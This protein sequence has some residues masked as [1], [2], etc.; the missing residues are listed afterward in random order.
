MPNYGAWG[1][2]AQGGDSLMDAYMASKAMRQKQEA[3]RNKL[4]MEQSAA[5]SKADLEAAQARKDTA[6]AAQTEYENAPSTVSL[7]RAGLPDPSAGLPLS[8]KG[9]NGESILGPAQGAFL[10][11]KE[12]GAWSAQ[13]TKAKPNGSAPNPNWDG[14]LGSLHPNDQR[15]VEALYTGQMNPANISMRQGERERVLNLVHGVHPDYDEKNFP[16]M[17]TTIKS[18]ASGPDAGNKTSLNTVIGHLG[19]LQESAAQLANGSYPAVNAVENFVGRQMGHGK[20][21]DF[22]T[23]ADAVASE[24]GKVFKGTGALSDNEI[25]E[26]RHNLSQN[27]SP[28]QFKSAIDSM[29]GLIASR[30]QALKEKYKTGTGR[31]ADFKILTPESE[32]MLKKL[33]HDPAEVEGGMV[34]AGGND[35]DFKAAEKVLRNPGAY[36]P[37]I[38]SQAKALTGK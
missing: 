16:K 33:G 17:S 25:K 31:D 30:S 2:I 24:M 21:V 36:T 29:V 37:D 7:S 18:F 28:E 32:A 12:R 13:R 20:Q 38:V 10:T 6:G 9:P 19:H 23:K 3:D 5:K 27:M 22:A 35:E 15:M 26:W 11:N 14:S 34:E 1:A 4:A 8:Q